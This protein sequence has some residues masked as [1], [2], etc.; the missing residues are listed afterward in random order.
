MI[1]LTCLVI[2]IIIFCVVFKLTGALLKAC[3]WLAIKLPAGLLLICLGI[4][5]CCTIILIPIG[6]KSLKE[7]IHVLF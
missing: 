7:G 6:I 1:L 3:V 4:A 5:L 2:L